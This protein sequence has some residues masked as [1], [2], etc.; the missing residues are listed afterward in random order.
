MSVNY[1]RAKVF[2]CG[3]L[4]CC[5]LKPDTDPAKRA[6][7]DF[8]CTEFSSS[9]EGNQEIAISYWPDKESIIAWKNDP[10]HLQAQQQGKA[11]WYKSY[12][13]QVVEIS[14]QYEFA[15]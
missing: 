2:I 13:V 11:K 10:V 8:G 7:R 12:R 4:N 15:P 3:D 6:L 9:T 14:H 1:P 5:W